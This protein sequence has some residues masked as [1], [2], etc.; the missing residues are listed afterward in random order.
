MDRGWT[1]SGFVDHDRVEMAHSFEEEDCQSKWICQCVVELVAGEFVEQ[2]E[3]R[4][5]DVKCYEHRL[6]LRRG[7]G[8]YRTWG[9]RWSVIW[10]CVNLVVHA[11]LS[12]Q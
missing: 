2:S 6:F 11:A 10:L 5:E 7:R 3:W 1:A 8:M 12:E 4:V 9:E